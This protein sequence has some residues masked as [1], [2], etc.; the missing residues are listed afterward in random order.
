MV[1]SVETLCSFNNMDINSI[2]SNNWYI[3]SNGDVSAN[4]VS[5]NSIYV[6]NDISANKWD[7][8]PTLAIR[9]IYIV[10]CD[11]TGFVLLSEMSVKRWSF[12]ILGEYYIRKGILQF[13]VNL[14]YSL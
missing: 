14:R 10:P 9:G 7:I 6:T 5:F 11:L 8:S 13:L 2:E 3:K 4:D 1:M 12:V